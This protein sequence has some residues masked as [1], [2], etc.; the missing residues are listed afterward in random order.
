MVFWQLIIE[1]GR[2][3]AR[4][5]MIVNNKKIEVF[6]GVVTD[7]ALAHFRKSPIYHDLLETIWEKNEVNKN[8]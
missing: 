1:S 4:L 5:M 6:R 3:T 7:E 8:E 2:C